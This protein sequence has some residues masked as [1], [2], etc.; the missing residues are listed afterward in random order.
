PSEYPHTS[1]GTAGDADPRTPTRAN[2]GA[3]SI[4]PIAPASQLDLTEALELGNTP[5][6][7]VVVVEDTSF[8][9]S[10]LAAEVVNLPP[11]PR[12]TMAASTRKTWGKIKRWL[13]PRW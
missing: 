4:S 12:H 6:S 3:T 10:P 1:A 8:V 7:E 5:V 9:M 11:L 13:V 2:S